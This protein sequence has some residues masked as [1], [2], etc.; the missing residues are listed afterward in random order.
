[1]V[2]EKEYLDIKE[3]YEKQKRRFQNISL[4][5]LV[6]ETI[7]R[8]F[9]LE[10]FPTVVKKINVEENYLDVVDV[11]S[12]NEEKRYFSFLTKSEMIEEGFS[13]QSIE[14]AYK[15]YSKTIENVIEYSLKR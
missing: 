1:M 9:E 13:K 4:G 8:G 11:S 14:E 12:N 10:Y 2:N 7:S 5:D 15:K 6:W 3:R